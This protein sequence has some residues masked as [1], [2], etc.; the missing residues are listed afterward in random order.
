MH[1]HGHIAEDR[2]WT[3]RRNYHC[4]IIIQ[5]WIGD[6][7]EFAEFWFIFHF[8]VGKGGLTARTPV[9]DVFTFVDQTFF[10]KP[11][12]DRPHGFREAFIHGEPFSAPVT[13]GA[14]SFELRYYAGAITLLPLPYHLYERFAPDFLTGETL[15]GQ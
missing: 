3:R 14:K 5:E 10:V 13:G 7:V 9:Y 1:C 6:K 2:L 11:Y 4:S 12:K 15:F 8:K